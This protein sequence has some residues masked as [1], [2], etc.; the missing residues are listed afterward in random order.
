M[1]RSST[2]TAKLSTSTNDKKARTIGWTEA[3]FASSGMVGLSCRRSVTQNVTI[4]ARRSAEGGRS[5]L[6]A[7]LAGLVARV[8]HQRALRRNP[9]CLPARWLGL[10]ATNDRPKFALLESSP[11]AGEIVRLGALATRTVPSGRQPV[12][13]G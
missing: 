6:A 13:F 8:A 2:S 3:A 4:P 12:R 9:R 1:L 5:V 11:L 7:L 10:W